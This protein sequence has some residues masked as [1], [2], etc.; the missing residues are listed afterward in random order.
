MSTYVDFGEAVRALKE[1]KRVRCDDWNSDKKFI[2]QQVNSIIG[3]DVV[4]K[5]QS[6]PQNV[7]DYFQD[8]LILNRSK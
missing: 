6:L 3:K 5:M 2:F 4:P 1:G 7:K 8:T